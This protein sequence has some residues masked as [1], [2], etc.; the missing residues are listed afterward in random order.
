MYTNI[1]FLWLIRNVG[2]LNPDRIKTMRNTLDIVISMDWSKVFQYTSTLFTT[3]LNSSLLI[4]LSHP[5]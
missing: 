1:N 4:I 2:K 5:A 3:L